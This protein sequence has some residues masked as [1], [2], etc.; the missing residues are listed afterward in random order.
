[1]A[2]PELKLSRTPADRMLD[3]INTLMMLAM[4]LIPTINYGS[5]PE[6]IAIHYD[7]TGNADRYGDKIMIW[8]LTGTSLFIYAL[9]RWLTTVPHLHNY[10]VEV[11]ADNAEKLYR[12]SNR[13]IRLL[14]GS[15]LV[16][17]L[18]IHISV[19]YT[20]ASLLSGWFTPMLPVLV[21]SPVIWGLLRMRKIGR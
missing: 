18:I 19:I 9:L 7:I 11:T 14:T 17:F 15:I 8:L 21:L 16:I 20:R 12:T 4:V 6:T 1:M 3:R 2:Q 5:M 10:P 13:L